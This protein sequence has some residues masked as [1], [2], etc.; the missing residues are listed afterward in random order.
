MLAW[1]WTH[2]PNGAAVL[3]DLKAV[4]AAGNVNDFKHA[5]RKWDAVSSMEWATIDMLEVILESRD[6]V[7]DVKVVVLHRELTASAEAGQIDIAKYLIEERGCV[8]YPTAVRAA[9]ER[10]QWGVLE[11]FLK[12]G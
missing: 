4:A 1:F 10:E 6:D 3:E 11:L 2:A 9:L 7:R 5:M 8:V 12:K